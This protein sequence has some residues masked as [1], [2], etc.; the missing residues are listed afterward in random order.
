MLFFQYNV[1]SKKHKQLLRMFTIFIHHLQKYSFLLDMYGRCVFNYSR[2]DGVSAMNKKRLLRLIP[3][4]GLFLFLLTGCSLKTG[5]L[6][7]QGPV[8]QKQYDLIM[9]SVILMMFIF[10]TVSIL[11]VYMIVKYRAKPENE[12]YEP[13]DIEGS[14]KLEVIWTLIPVVIV[15]LLAIPTVKTTFELETSPSPHKEPMVIEVTSADWKW[16]FKYP[17]QGI[18][19]VNHLKIPAGVPIKFELNAVGPMNSFWIPELGGQEYTMPDMEM[20]LWL[21]A[22]RPGVY[23]GRS[24]NFSGEGFTHMTFDVNSVQASDFDQW[25]QSVKKSA[26][27]LT[28]KEYQQLLEPGLVDEK[29][30]S[31]FPQAEEKQEGHH[32][33]TSA[34]HHGNHESHH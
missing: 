30:Y 8:A 22:D 27:K 17:E 7:P 29:T 11:F 4:S 10:V 9:W 34:D 28:E 2:K 19:T 6:N 5:I 23:Q 21:E 3:L 18:A 15:T 1:S 20:V 14:R 33:S 13:P 12:G 25:V 26:P 32:G 31:S 16:I 24:A